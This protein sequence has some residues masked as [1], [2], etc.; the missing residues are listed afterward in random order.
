MIFS[1]RKIIT[2]LAAAT[3][4]TGVSGVA[5]QQQG[6]SRLEEVVITARRVEENLQDVPVAISAFSAEEMRKRGMRELEDIALATPGFSFEDYGGG[7]GVPVIRGASQLRIQDLDQ[8]T[9]VFLD[10]IY[11]PRQYMV[12]FGT[13][14][15]E[16]VEVAKGPQSALF[17]RNAFSGA[18]NYVSGGPTEELAG[19]IEVTA[20]TDELRE[21]SVEVSGPIIEGKLGGRLLYAYSE[22]DG[23]WRNDWPLGDGRDYGT[24]GTTGNLGG[25]ENATWGV[26]LEATPTE[27]LLLEFDYY[28]VSRFQESP[29]SVRTSAP[30]DANCVQTLRGGFR[31]VCGELPDT[32]T[33]RPG[34][35]PEGTR[36][37]ADPRNY[38]LDVETD[39]AMVRASYDFSD[40]WTAV[41]QFGYADTEVSALG[42]G[43]RDPLLGSPNFFTGATVNY[44]QATPNGTNQY[45]SHEFRIQ[46]NSGQWSG[47][48]GVFTSRLEDYD[49]FDFGFGPFLDPEPIR[50]DPTDGIQGIGKFNLGI[51]ENEF[52]TDAIFGRVAYETADARWRFSAEARYQDEKKTLTNLRGATPIV[53]SNKWDSLTPRF[54][55]DYRL[56]DNQMLYMSVANGEK[57]GG[58][59]GTVFNEVQR[60]YEP[61]SNWTYEVGSKNDLL[62]GRLRLNVAVFYT[63]WEDLQITVTPL[64]IP[65]NLLVNPPGII[66]NTGG[67]EILGIEVEGTWF[68]TDMLY[69]DFAA[70][71]NEA[72][73]ESGAITG[74][75][76]LANACD[77]ILC[78]ADGSIGGNQLQRQPATQL[79]MG[80]NLTGTVAGGWDWLARADVNYQSKQ[81]TDEFNLGWVPDRTLVNMRAQMSNQ[82]WSIALWGKNVFDEEYTANSFATLLPTASEY[83]AVSGQKATFGLSV[84][85][86]F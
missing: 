16:R 45:A 60:L 65:A 4:A 77:D 84:G 46:Y 32:F 55:A 67:A 66:G 48:A 27:G 40:S 12:D 13:V 30:L 2:A 29:S 5:A 70:S 59:N 19:A 33:P 17:G 37:I 86:S 50:V 25:W 72:E 62:D 75:L 44:L 78:A 31:F 58:F 21:G 83:A 22:F 11:L 3:A 74:R 9:S 7:F 57:A 10:G 64:D 68:A 18:V 42:T 15:F 81:Y 35:S 61:D 63:D 23:T 49:R 53:F 20:G 80:L 51:T 71:H 79:S 8:T 1:K 52:E 56:N 76:G 85:Y 41:Y 43:D 54:T 82:N 24:R 26:N 69:F 38:L 6:A 34:G 39:F 47:L 28:N 14:G 73:Y 36:R